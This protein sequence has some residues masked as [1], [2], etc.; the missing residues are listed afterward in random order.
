[1]KF[2]PTLLLI[3]SLTLSF[4]VPAQTETRSATI[5]RCGPD[6]RDLR[7]S[8]CP[9]GM[10]A[11]LA[12]ISFDQPGGTQVQAAKDQAADTALQADQLQGQRQHR[13]A[14]ERRRASKVASIDG[15]AGAPKAQPTPPSKSTELKPPKTQ[16]SR[17]PRTNTSTGG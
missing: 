17:K 1:M 3:S 15:L 12:Q 8:P 14:L 13:E 16:R 4:S 11:K 7:E 6:G 10:Q 9:A 2:A 5:Y